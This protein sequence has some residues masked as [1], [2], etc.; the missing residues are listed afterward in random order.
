MKYSAHKKHLHLDARKRCAHGTA[1]S[2]AHAATSRPHRC[3]CEVVSDKASK[4][5][6]QTQSSKCCRW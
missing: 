3:A 2:I 6:A 5:S 4:L 1:T